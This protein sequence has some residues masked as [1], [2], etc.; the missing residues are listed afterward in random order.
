MLPNFLGLGAARA[1]STW[2]AQNL[3]QHPD[4]YLPGKKEVHFF[5]RHYQA[6]W[7]YYEEQ[8]SSWSGQRM[9]GEIT[10]QYFHNPAVPQLIADHLP[11]IKLFVCLRNPIDRAYSHY[12]RLIAVSAF[13]QNTSFEEVINAPN[14]VLEV[15]CYYNH[16]QRYFSFFPE[17]QILVLIFDDL[18]N[19]PEVF[20]A[21]IYDFLEVDNQ[22]TLPLAN[23][24]INAAASLQ[25]L[26]RSKLM[27]QLYR[28]VS[29]LRIYPL[30]DRL[31]RLNSRDLP[32]MQ[33]ETHQFLVNY[34]QEQID[35]LQKLIDRDLSN[36][37][38]PE[39]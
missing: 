13:D 26:S 3:K 31:Q 19:S 33:P 21:Q 14:D 16:L 30:A 25:N 7:P 37:L 11:K 38:Q 20:L 27:W 8:F 15:G 35:G 22:P 18:E 39:V 12:W 1:G 4:I 36:W 23:Q 28:L 5:D 17:K 6:G 24:K 9:V 10:P 29:R 32:P 2:I 34:Y